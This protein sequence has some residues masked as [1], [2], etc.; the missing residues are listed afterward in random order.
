VRSDQSVQ[1]LEFRLRQLPQTSAGELGGAQRSGERGRAGW[2]TGL[3]SSDGESGENDDGVRRE[4]G[5]EQ[6]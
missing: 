2:W 5:P 4:T 1:F 6:V 3:G